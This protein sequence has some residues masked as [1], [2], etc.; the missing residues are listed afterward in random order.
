MN[1][2]SGFKK[3]G[4]CP[5]KPKEINDQQMAPSKAFHVTEKHLHS[6]E[7]S[8]PPHSDS[9]A[10]A[11]AVQASSSQVTMFQRRYEKGYD[12][13]DP[14]YISWLSQNHPKSVAPESSYARSAPA[15]LPSS[16]SVTSSSGDYPDIGK[17]PTFV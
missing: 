6:E 11:S 3:S 14:E 4:I 12:A 16:F 15:A 1:I 8:C 9:S 2:Q 13:F 10:S 17:I 7:S 5:L